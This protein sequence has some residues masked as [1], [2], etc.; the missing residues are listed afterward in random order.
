MSQTLE[1]RVE[2]LERKLAGLTSQM[3]GEKSP[4]KDWRRT[5]GLSR[6]DDG[7]KEM[8]R[9]GREY[10]ESLRDEGSGADS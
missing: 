6:G 3:G 2:V 9:L 5:F 1:E 4:K 10:R 8:V 7:F